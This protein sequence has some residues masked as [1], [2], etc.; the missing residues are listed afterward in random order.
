MR[1][2]SVQGIRLYVEDVG[3]GPVVLVA[4]G[5]FGS[6]AS[7]NRKGLGG[8]ELAA[9]GFRVVQ[10]DARGHGRSE[11]TRQSAD[12]RWE[13]LADDMIGVMDAL[14]LSRASILGTSM[15]AGVALLVALR[16]PERVERLVLRMPPPMGRDLR[17]V[18][19]RFG[20]LK[21]LHRLLGHTR[22][23]AALAAMGQHTAADMLREQR[24]ELVAPAI[25]GL[26]FGQPQLPEERVTETRCPTLLMTHPGDPEHPLRSGQILKRIAG[27]TL[28]AASTKAYF[29][30]H[31]EAVMNAVTSFLSHRA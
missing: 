11:L 10:Y 1:H 12:Y 15:G 29:R 16:A 9:R 8:A 25:D 19:L 18:R 20:A 4:H 13:A 23:I 24:A 31:P 3:S 5:L 26:L 22:T 30:T 14:D 21:R 17:R 28:L 27:S 6:V 2:V 7:S